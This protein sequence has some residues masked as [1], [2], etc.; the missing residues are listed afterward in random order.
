MGR[1]FLEGY[2]RIGYVHRIN[3][4]VSFPVQNSCRQGESDLAFTI[5]TNEHSFLGQQVPIGQVTNELQA[6]FAGDEKDQDS[7]ITRASLINLAIYQEGPE[8]L[9]V[10]AETVAEIVQEAACRSILIGADPKGETGAKAWVQA[11]CQIL[12]R[13]H[14]KTVCTE[15]LA[16]Q[17]TGATPGLVRNTVFAHLDSDLPLVF[18]WRGEFS[19]AFSDRLFTRIDRLVF[20][21]CSWSDPR[22]Q[23]LRLRQASAEAKASFIP[24]DLSFT[25]LNPIRSSIA[26]CFDDPL[27][28][29]EASRIS[30]VEIQHGSNFRMPA[31]YLAAW[32]ATRLKCD[33]LANESDTQSFRFRRRSSGEIS[34]LTV[35]LKAVD[36]GCEAICSVDMKS[37]NAHFSL[38]RKDNNRFWELTSKIGNCPANVELLPMPD[39]SDAV[40][41]TEILMRGGRNHVLCDALKVVREMLV[42]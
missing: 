8:S 18:W 6:L 23:F 2:D 4:V 29:K 32:L 12:G 35:N 19:E 40:L 9:E 1:R 14:R 20:N 7:G 37:N 34:G 10:A 28:R 36:E 30:S 24:H 16:F 31:L 21:S 13:D 17:L 3:R 26:R 27:P 22:S 5:E 41:V 42:I 25:R 11:H 39:R 38:N 15:Q 33:L